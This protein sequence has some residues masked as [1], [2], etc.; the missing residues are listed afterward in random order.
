MNERHTHPSPERGFSR[1]TFLKLS[2][3]AGLAGAL[4]S[5]RLRAAREPINRRAIPGSG[6]RIP[7]IGLG[8]ARTFDV[9]PD[10]AAAMEPLRGVLKNFFDGGGRLVDSSPMY[11]EA[12]TV[13]GRLAADLG[14]AEELF[15]ATKVWTRGPEDGIAQME[16]SRERMGGGRLDL[17]QVHNLVDLQT[18]LHTLK[19]WREQGRVRYI[20]VTHSQTWHHDDLTRIVEN[21]PIDFV[22]LNYNIA[23]RNAEKRLLPAAADNGVA[24]LI[25]EPFESGSLF[26]RVRGAELPPWASELGVKSWAQFFLKFIVGHPA[27]TCVIPAT[28][29]PKHAADNIGAGHGGLPDA[30][31]RERMARYFEAI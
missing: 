5:P 1:R 25:N 31:Q 11:G 3:A 18:Q 21:E 27:V 30:K 29:D 14:I 7:V 20:G 12:E 10:T 13:V 24:T 28:S 9:N 26:R 23:A 17:I 2:A 15:M 16:R 19:A 6:E 4:G 22:Q 8:T